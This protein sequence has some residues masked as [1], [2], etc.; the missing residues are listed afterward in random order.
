MT[1]PLLDLSFLLQVSDNDPV[2]ISDVLQLFLDTAA[3]GLKKLHEAI[4]KGGD[5][6]TIR[7]SAHF[8]KSSSNVVKIRGMYD[9]LCRIEVLAKESIG[10]ED[11]IGK[12]HPVKKEIS[13]LFNDIMTNYTEALPLIKAEKKKAMQ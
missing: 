1:A 13:T 3:G 8:L 4:E 11:M 7:R 10:K 9:N 5:F 2:Y 12:E 6:D